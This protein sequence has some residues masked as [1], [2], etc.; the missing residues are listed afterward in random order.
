MKNR[1]YGENLLYNKTQ[2]KKNRNLWMLFALV[3]II[4]TGLSSCRNSGT[5]AAKSN[6]GSSKKII[7]NIHSS[8]TISSGV[9][10]SSINSSKNEARSSTISSNSP[11]SKS[12]SSG[13][14][15]SNTKANPSSNG[16]SAN[17]T[18]SQ[19]PS[20]SNSSSGSSSTP[21]V[22]P[23]SLP[24]LIG[25]NMP[26]GEMDYSTKNTSNPSSGQDYLFVSHQD[27]DYIKS[28]GMNFIR[29]LFSWEGMQNTLNGPL[30]TNNYANDLIDCVNYATS[31]GMYV[32]IE[33]HGAIS[34]DFGAYRGNKVGST[35]VPD[36]AFADFWGKMAALYK[37]NSHV[38]IGLSNEPHDKTG[39]IHPL[40]REAQKQQ[41]QQHF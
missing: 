1:L 28:K 17:V 27:I 6:T 36:S 34:D 3:F 16:T 7:S 24:M 18:S 25:A 33:P 2:K 15:S 14:S 38:L 31:K 32:L 19:S 41:I 11:S 37:S 22:S 12:N 30:S 35:Q 40:T 29:L 5:E 21:P 13:I 20:S 8:S 9:F 23:T 26:G 39:Q 10:S 4:M